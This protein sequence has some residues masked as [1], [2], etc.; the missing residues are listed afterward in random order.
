MKHIH[1]FF[2]PV[3]LAFGACVP[4]AAA[5]SFH[6]VRVLRLRAGDAV[7]LAGGD[8]RVF[9]GVIAAG[10]VTGSDAVE[11]VVGEEIQAAPEAVTTGRPVFSVVQALPRGRR[12]D[13]VVEKLSELGVDRL[14][15][16]TSDRSVAREVAGREGKLERWR[17]VARAA[18]AQA[19]RARIME[20]AAPVPLAEW[21]SAFAGEL[22]VLATE[23]E[24]TPLG[25]AVNA[26][27]GMA[28]DAA[29]PLALVVGPEAG[30]SPGEIEMLSA[31]GAVF[32]SLGPLVLRTETAA[33]VAATIVMHH[34]GAIG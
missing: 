23:V 34:L 26:R 20:I 10:A 30:F 28:R 25:A 2:V 33:L 19:K 3:P 11:V 5:D 12:M 22:L 17:R 14:A 8:S 24:G 13:L 31:G 29:R 27:P 6:A 16:V 7:E 4:L 21:L 15:P 32:V 9:A 18:A 1:R